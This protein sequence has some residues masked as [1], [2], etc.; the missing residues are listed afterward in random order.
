MTPKSNRKAKFPTN[1]RG[2][3]IEHESPSSPPPAQKK[4]VDMISW[5]RTATQPTKSRAKPKEKS[6]SRSR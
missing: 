2:R 1:K 5:G 6:A 4:R 3:E